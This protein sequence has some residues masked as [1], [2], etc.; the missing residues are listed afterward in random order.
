MKINALVYVAKE[1]F[2]PETVSQAEKVILESAGQLYEQRVD[3]LII[4]ITATTETESPTG[5]PPLWKWL[6]ANNDHPKLYFLYGPELRVNEYGEPISELTQD[7]LQYWSR[8]ALLENEMLRIS[9]EIDRLEQLPEVDFDKID[10]LTLMLE[11]RNVVMEST[12]ALLEKAS[13]KE[14]PFDEL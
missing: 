8:L 14:E 1:P 3:G 2:T 5:L 12:F 10:E 4:L 13:K 6:R 9:S 7:L 11:Q